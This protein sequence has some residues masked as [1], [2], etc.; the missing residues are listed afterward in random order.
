MGSHVVGSKWYRCIPSVE[1]TMLVH[2]RGTFY[3]NMS[4]ADQDE[5]RLK[6]DSRLFLELM[7]CSEELISTESVRANS[8]CSSRKRCVGTPTESRIA[9]QARKLKQGRKPNLIRRPPAGGTT[10]RVNRKQPECLEDTLRLSCNC[11]AK[12][13]LGGIIERKEEHMEHFNITFVFFFGEVK[14]GPKKGGQGWNGDEGM[15]KD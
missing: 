15:D 10:E 12:E 8:T 11:M 3:G 4:P 2:I 7:I 5:H 14:F 13:D 9:Y 1:Q 6:L